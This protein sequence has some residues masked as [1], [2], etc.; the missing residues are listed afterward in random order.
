MQVFNS[1][2]YDELQQKLLSLNTLFNGLRTQHQRL[3]HWQNEG[4]LIL[5]DE[6]LVGKTFVSQTDKTGQIKQVEQRETY[7]YVP[8]KQ[9]LQVFLQQP[10]V[11]SA[12]LEDKTSKDTDILE[13]FYDGSFFQEKVSTAADKTDNLVLPILL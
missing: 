12:I 7:Q 2:V 10:G 4:L 1:V 13:S 3:D 6:K 8:I 5:P 11:I 9:T